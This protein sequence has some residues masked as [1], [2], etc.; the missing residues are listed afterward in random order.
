MFSKPKATKNDCIITDLIQKTTQNKNTE[1][2]DDHDEQPFSIDSN[3]EYVNYK[4]VTKL[5]EITKG[6]SIGSLNVRS[7]LKNANKVKEFLQISNIDVLAVQETWHSDSQFENYE[8]IQNA[9]KNKRG[10]GTG[11]LVKKDLV[12]KEIDK[13]MSSDLEV[14]GIRVNG[15]DLWSTYL[16]SK[17]IVSNG[18]ERLEELINQDRPTYVLGDLNIDTNLDRC[19][20]SE[21]SPAER[22]FDFCRSLTMYPL[23]RNPTRVT[24]KSATTIDH[25]ITNESNEITAGVMTVDVADHLCPFVIVKQAEK[26][27][28]HPAFKTTRSLKD[29]NIERL[30]LDLLGINWQEELKDKDANQKAAAFGSIM[31]SLL[32]KNCPE[33]SRKFNKNVD[34]IEPWITQGMLQSR[35][36]KNNLYN[37]WITTKDLRIFQKYK[38]YKAIY[39]NLIKQSHRDHSLELFEKNCHDSRK[40]WRITNDIL[41]RKRKGGQTQKSIVFSHKG[42]SISDNKEIANEFNSYFVSIGESL[43]NQFKRTEKYTTY[44][45]KDFNGSLTLHE[46]HEDNVRN[47]I[48]RMKNKGSTGFDAMSNLLLKSLKECLI[49]PI[50][51]IVNTSIR[52]GVVP[53]QWKI[54]KVIPLHKGG[55]S[56][57]FN[58]YRPISLLSVYS[59]VLEKVVHNQLYRYAEEKILT[60]FQFGFRTKHETVQ[61]VM[62]YMQNI[63]T[64]KADKHHV[65][66]FIDI[67]KAFDSCDHKILLRKLRHYGLN[68]MAVKWFES[69]LTGRKQV[70]VYGGEH[71]EELALTCGVPQG[72]ILGPL[73]FLIFINDM[74]L[75]TELATTLFADDTT[76]QMSGNNWS[77]LLKKFNTELSKIEQWF[78]ANHLTLHPGK[79]RFICHGVLPTQDPELWLKGQRI[80]R[81]SPNHDEKAFKFLGLWIDQNLDWKIHNQKVTEKLRKIGFTLVQLKKFLSQKHLEMIYKGIVKPMYEYGIEIWGHSMTKE[82]KK[83][84]K[85]IVRVINHKPKHAHVEPLLKGMNVMQIEDVYHCKVFAS[86]LKIREERCPRAISEYCKFQ[87]EDS[88]RWFQIQQGVKSNK[89][90]KSLPKFHQIK[91]WNSTVKA[92]RIWLLSLENDAK[93]SQALKQVIIDT[94]YEYC[95]LKNCFSCERQ[96]SLDQAE[97]QKAIAKADAARQEPVA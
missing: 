92:D 26:G 15:M 40:M 11:F 37:K 95:T 25:I 87:N 81:I 42:R 97:L 45:P 52:T 61:A 10:G 23:I 36:T 46:V 51:D 67:K 78:D 1:C 64:K 57:S 12:F 94:Y 68:N 24:E 47:I 30:R 85:K 31:K 84:N 41:K 8:F 79:T 6:F 22:L 72:S 7:M 48:K 43:V 89:I 33:K 20:N 77:E 65:S 56:T 53:D 66:V 9:R 27:R 54:A 2:T 93:A 17:A 14:S 49:R 69:Y 29:E 73:L 35:V 88:R 70:T 63:E 75:A 4:P 90:E 32:D 58:N 86:L 59:K 55:D 60:N 16:P 34:A 19:N 83:A 38:E 5:S 3:V 71:S 39:E 13:L 62:N 28:D 80:A 76:Y 96:K 44:L 82:L 21:A 50:T 91:S 18:L 74:P